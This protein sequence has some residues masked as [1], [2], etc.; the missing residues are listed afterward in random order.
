MKR[1]SIA[2][3]LMLLSLTPFRAES[4]PDDLDPSFGTGGQIIFG[5]DS[6]FEFP[7]AELVLLQNGDIIYANGYVLWRVSAEG[8]RADPVDLGFVCA[9]APPQCVFGIDALARQPDGKPLIAFAMGRVGALWN[10]VGVARLNADGSPDLLFGTGGAAVLT[11][12]PPGFS[13]SP[14]GIAVQADGGLLVAGRSDRRFAFDR[15][16]VLARFLAGGA[17]DRAFG[18][19]GILRVDG[20]LPMAFVHTSNGNLVFASDAELSGSSPNV[21]AVESKLMRLLPTG[22]VDATFD[23]RGALAGVFFRP[24]ALVEQGDGKL[25][26]AGE[27]ATVQDFVATSLGLMRLDA[28]GGRDTSFGSNG[29]VVLPLDADRRVEGAA[30][31]LDSKNRIVVAMTAHPFRPDIY[32]GARIAVA[33]LLPDGAVDTLFAGGGLTTLQTP[34]QLQSGAVAVTPSGGI[35]IGGDHYLQG[36]PAWPDPML[37]RLHG[38]EGSV[39]R[40]IREERAVEFYHAGLGHYAVAATQREIATLDDPLYDPSRAWRRTGRSFRVWSGDAPHLSPV[41][42]FFSGQSFA[43]KSSHFYTPY[44][45]ECAS[46]RAGSTWTFE[47][48]PFR[49]Q[50]PT[51]TPAGLGCPAGSVPLYRAYNDGLGGAPNHRYTDDP[52]ILAS[53]QD[54][55]WAFEGDVQTKVFAC[56]PQP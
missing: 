31:A 41:C 26:V 52:A 44:V 54:Q 20:F 49:L 19:N 42:R 48:E 47:G 33:R 13:F 53:M 34:D 1:L 9:N 12:P 29:M 11:T 18:D 27:F 8:E 24:R 14:I 23:A 51:P 22:Q 36:S 32:K 7:G 17:P 4:A 38:G 16:L 15:A 40:P 56:I 45:E 28:Q 39:S 37:L 55:G 10:M 50:L 6:Y 35:L 3:P 30:V 25:I 46:L 5:R 2:L 21:L 43:P